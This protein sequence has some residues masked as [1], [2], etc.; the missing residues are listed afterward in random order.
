MVARM[1]RRGQAGVTEGGAPPVTEFAAVPVDAAAVA[2][3][4]VVA[5]CVL[6]DA[7]CFASSW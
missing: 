5:P 2:P 4:P 7:A 3:V 1:M 6:D